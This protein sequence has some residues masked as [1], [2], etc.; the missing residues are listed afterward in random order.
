MVRWSTRFRRP[1]AARISGDPEDLSDDD[2][3]TFELDHPI[4]YITTVGLQPS[5]INSISTVTFRKD[6]HLI[7]G[8]DCSVCLSEFRDD[9]TLR[10]LPKCNHAF[11]IPCIDTWLRSHT[12]C[13]LCRAGILSNGLSAVLSPGDRS[14]SR[15][16]AESD[17]N[18]PME[19]SV[20][21]DNVREI[22]QNV[23]L[24]GETGEETEDSK[25]EHE[26]ATA[27]RMSISVDARD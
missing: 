10:L 24:E 12:N 11:H 21:S 22:D 6:D 17:A 27:A 1:P 15:G 7:D 26:S 20:L 18:T 13:P 25:A 5:V 23:G 14:V 9:E 4:W 16:R 8:S 19:V 3:P 2:D